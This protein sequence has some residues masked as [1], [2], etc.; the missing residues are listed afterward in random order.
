MIVF[1]QSGRNELYPREIEVWKKGDLLPEWISD[2]CKI[3]SVTEKGELIP[4]IRP[5]SRGGFDILD[6]N[7]HAIVST[8]SED[9]YVCYGESK[10][11]SLSELQINLLY[12]LKN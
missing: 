11:F 2:N 12:K 5:N 9:D 7:N 6:I 3:L 1:T 10:I 8:S 4:D